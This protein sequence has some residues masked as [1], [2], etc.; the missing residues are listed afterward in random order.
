MQLY[1]NNVLY[2]SY[3]EAGVSIDS[4]ITTNSVF[5]KKKQ[6]RSSTNCYFIFR[7]THSV[8][9]RRIHDLLQISIRDK[10]PK[11]LI[12]R[13]VLHLGSPERMDG[14]FEG[15]GGMDGQS[16]MEQM[17]SQGNSSAGNEHRRSA[18]PGT[19][20]RTC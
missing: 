1:C 3:T 8:I 19:M 13:V 6:S 10:L 11:C 15:M 18:P 7:Q 12:Y 9:Y 5:F 4:S 14:A 16:L 20:Y 17:N 2:N